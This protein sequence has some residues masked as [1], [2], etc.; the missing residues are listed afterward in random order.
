MGPRNLEVDAIGWYSWKESNCQIFEGKT[1]CFQV[2]NF[3]R[4]LYSWSQVLDP[5]TKLTILDFVDMIISGR[6]RVG[7]YFV[8]AFFCA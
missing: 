3:L 5:N 1:R 2:F 4:T 6:L 7:C 8:I